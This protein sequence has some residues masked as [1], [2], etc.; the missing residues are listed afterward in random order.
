MKRFCNQERKSIMAVIGYNAAAVNAAYYLNQNTNALNQSISDLASGSRLANPSTDAAGVA[1]SGN[2]TATIARLGAASQAVGDVVSFAQT[3]DGFLSTIQQELSRMSELAQS[4]T[5]GAFGSAD[6]ANYATEFTTLQT[7]IDSIVSNASFNG[8]SLFTAG[9]VTVGVDANGSTDSFTT[10]TLGNTT[11]LGIN[12]I[13]IGT[14]TAAATAIGLLTTAITSL[15]SRRATVNADISKF[16]FYTQNIATETTNLQ[17]ANSA[18]SDVDVATES[19]Q[20]AKNNI[21]VS[22][23]SSMLAQANSSQQSIL[24]L[25]QH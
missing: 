18:I 12:G 9:S 19:T 4:A 6:R 1:V 25:L 22:A 8:S 23:S 2:I 3:T 11:S 13:T 5:N 14:T 15:T 21:L 17:S 24:T 7:Q 10:S 16:N 20:L